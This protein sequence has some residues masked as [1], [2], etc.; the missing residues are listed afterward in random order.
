M[1]RL[2]QVFIWMVLA[3]GLALQA[4]PGAAQALTIEDF[5]AWAQTAIRAEEAVEAG[6]ASDVAMQGLRAELDQWRQA[7]ADAQSINSRTIAAVEAQLGALG[8]APEDGNEPEDI[9]LQRADLSLRMAELQAPAKSAQVALS[10]ANVLISTIDEILRERQTEELLERGPIP[11]NPVIWPRGW[12]AL[13]LSLQNTRGEILNAWGNNVQRKAFLENLPAVIALASLGLLLLLLSRRWMLRWMHAVQAR[14]A[15]PTRWL[16]AFA[17]SLGQVVLPLLGLAA[18]V[19][20]AYLTELVGLRV[21]PLLGEVVNGGLYVFIALWLGVRIFPKGEALHYPMHFSP[22]QLRQGRLITG[23]IGGVLALRGFLAELVR[24]DN[25]SDPARAVVFFPLI[26]LGGVLV[27]QLGRLLRLHGTAALKQ[28]ETEADA[29]RFTEQLYRL[30]GVAL[31]VLAFAGPLL[32]AVGYLPAAQRALFPTL[33]SLLL[34]GFVLVIQRVLAEV[35]VLARGREEARDGLIPVLAGMVLIAVAAPRFALIWG[36]SR[37][38]LDEL[39]R[40]ARDGFQ[41][42]DT[43]ISLSDFLVFVVVFVTGYM[44]TRLVQGALKNTVLPKTR[45]EK[46]AQNS[47][48]S[49]IGYVGIFLAALIAITSAGI[50]LSSLAIV[51]GALSVGIGFGLQNIVSNFVSGII[52]LIERPISEGDW[53]EVGGTHGT[54]RDI[55][56]RSTRIE[57]FD[58]SD[59]ILPNAD[60]ISGKVTNYT[61]GKTVGRVIVPVGVAYGTDTKKVDAVLREIAEAHPMVLGHP[62]PSVVFQGFGAD[63][64]DF[65]IRA[66]LR[67]VNWILSVKSEM[68]H[69]IARRFAEEGI[70]IPFAQ[71]DVWLRNPEALRGDEP[72]ETGTQEPGEGGRGKSDAGEQLDDSDFD[73]PDG[74]GGDR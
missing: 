64:M 61:R 36:V 63:S 7:F 69:E 53:I 56:V 68:N 49:G 54:V 28:A 22:E 39:W 72:S 52:L 74:D 35:Y 29:V 13:T 1:G 2:R 42:G 57:T 3:L 34:L 47:F 46:G 55:S 15:T 58:R 38:Q 43:V 32:A 65:E 21:D 51:A 62:A 4:G 19:E 20:A 30:L 66:I 9:A 50:D 11:L 27:W 23:L 40:Q 17:L 45:M 24:Y 59:V 41:I 8:P 67:D 26:L 48:V 33:E 14:E 25:W 70:E 18:L 16:V 37:T 10:R 44:M 73:D 6:R 5:E 71:R 60:L 12:S 31:M